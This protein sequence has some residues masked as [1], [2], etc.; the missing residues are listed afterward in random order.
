MVQKFA[1]LSSIN[2]FYFVSSYPTLDNLVFTTYTYYIHYAKRKIELDKDTS[3][4]RYLYEKK[5]LLKVFPFYME[6]FVTFDPSVV[7]IVII[8]TLYVS[9]MKLENF[10]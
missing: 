4:T 7:R 1:K 10:T 9:D 5:H 3:A 2:V 6:I 8:F